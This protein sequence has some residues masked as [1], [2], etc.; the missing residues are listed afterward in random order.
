MAWGCESCLANGSMPDTTNPPD[1]QGPENPE[2]AYGGADAVEKT[3]YVVGKGTD[4]RANVQ[5]DTVPGNP[6]APVGK[7]GAS[8]FVWI[9]VAIA[10]IVGVVYV[11]GVVAR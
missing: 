11:L 6:P 8:W 2:A 3:T 4:P 9:V 5:G 1:Q 10:V 7:A